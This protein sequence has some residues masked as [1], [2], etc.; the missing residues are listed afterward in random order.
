MAYNDTAYIS[1]EDAARLLGKSQR[2]VYRYAEQGRLS[3]H[4]T[5]H[6]KVFDRANVE[7]L[8]AELSVTPQPVQP[9][10]ELVPLSDMLS[11]LHRKDD[12]LENKERV[13]NQ[14]MLRVGELQ[15]ELK[16]QQYLL[17]DADTTRQRLT[18]AEVERDRRK[19]N[20]KLCA[21]VIGGKG[22]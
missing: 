22:C 14:L 10:A 12:Q 9:A 4:D 16:H 21:G 1:I 19:K 15:N 7:A 8:A 2:T 20:W 6:G 13:I 3:A 11:E 17:K 5:P 18:T